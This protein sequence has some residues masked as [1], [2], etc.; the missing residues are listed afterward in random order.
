M[1][2]VMK[3]NLL[4]IADENDNTIGKA[5]Y[6]EAVGKGL[7]FRAANVIVF[8]SKGE[9]F[10][11]RRNTSLPT[12]PGMWDIKLGGIVDEGESYEEAAIRELKEEAGITG[13]KLEF[14]FPLK[15]RKGSY[16]N[17]RKVYRCVYDGKIKL[18]ESEIEKGRFVTVDEAKK[19]MRE[20]MLS[21]SAIAVFEE[22][23]KW[24]K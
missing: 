8:N 22:F 4:D 9:I 15:F 24:R 6:D 7:I 16:R 1:G 21:P 5:S 2:F 14:V 19:M 12:F 18:Q 17:N 10:A 23:L 20:G 13:A 11:H 3:G